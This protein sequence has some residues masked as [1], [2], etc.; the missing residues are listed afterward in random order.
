MDE[1]EAIKTGS[2]LVSQHGGLMAWGGAM[3]TVIGG[4]FTNRAKVAEIDRRLKDVEGR[5]WMT[6][7][8]R[9]CCR[10]LI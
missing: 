6:R 8:D 1:K 4:W 9:F 3:V 10:L 7:G 2:E 5:F